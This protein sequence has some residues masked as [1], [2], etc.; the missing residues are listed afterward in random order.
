MTPER[1]RIEKIFVLFA[2]SMSISR[3][4]PIRA[5]F[6]GFSFFRRRFSIYVFGFPATKS[7]SLGFTAEILF[8]VLIAFPVAKE[9]AAIAAP[10]PGLNPF[11]HG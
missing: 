10:P 5:V 6:F 9:R 1:A 2:N 11:V 3:R 4:S 7:G 8:A